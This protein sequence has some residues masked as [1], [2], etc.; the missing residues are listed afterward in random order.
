MRIWPGW[1]RLQTVRIIRTRITRRTRRSWPW[2]PCLPNTADDRHTS[3]VAVLRSRLLLASD[4]LGLAVIV[5]RADAAGPGLLDYFQACGIGDDAFAKFADDRQI[6]DEELDVIRRIAVRL[7]DCPADRL[8]RM[9]A[10]IRGRRH[11][12]AAKAS[13][14]RRGQGPAWA[15]VRT[16]RFPRVR[17][18][19]GGPGRRA[20]LAMHRDAF[21]ARHLPALRIS[22]P[23]R[24]LRGR[25]AGK[26]SRRRHRSARGDWTG[27]S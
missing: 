19:C 20:A 16:P 27:S 6:A 26:T 13:L 14:A 4:R 12:A 7:R 5:P 10:E 18:A 15:D 22:P 24:G 2:R 8:Q 25:G 21:S 1:G 23:G 17:G 9:T 3:H 11:R